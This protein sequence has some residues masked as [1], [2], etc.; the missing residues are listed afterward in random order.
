[1]SYNDGALLNFNIFSY[2]DPAMPCTIICLLFLC[3]LAAYVVGAQWPILL[4]L[5]LFI[6]DYEASRLVVGHPNLACNCQFSPSTHYLSLSPHVGCPATLSSE[7]HSVLLS[8]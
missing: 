5:L 1:M 8:Y 7:T 4:A 6:C 2:A 3:L